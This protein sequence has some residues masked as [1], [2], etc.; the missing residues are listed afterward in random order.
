MVHPKSLMTDRSWQLVTAIRA[1][2]AG[3]PSTAEIIEMALAHY[4]HGQAEYNPT[5]VTFNYNPEA[6]YAPVVPADNRPWIGVD[7]PPDSEMDVEI[8]LGV[9]LVDGKADTGY[10]LP[11]SRDWYH[12]LYGG[13]MRVDPTAWRELDPQDEDERG[14]ASD[15]LEVD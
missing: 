6:A 7:T 2:M 11:E 13:V 9:A 3:T 10:Y 5:T 14:A 8:N 1:Q 4:V 15:H 12:Y